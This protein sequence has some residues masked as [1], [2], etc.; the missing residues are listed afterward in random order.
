MKRLFKWKYP[1]LTLLLLM[2]ILAYF[3][4]SNPEVK[5]YLSQN[6]DKPYLFSFIAG[7]M[8]SF[9]FTAP[10]SVGLLITLN[11]SNIY[12]AAALGGLGALIA[13]LFIFNLIKFSFLDEF[14][15][16][17]N[18][19]TI[20]PIKNLIEKE[21]SHKIR[22]YLLYIFAGFVI[23]SPLPDEIGIT[24]LAGLTKIKQ[25]IFSILSFLLNS[26]GILII[27]LLSR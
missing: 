25:S 21:V 26:L 15:K 27:L 6:N 19:K 8:F 17:E 23:A 12:L 1:K 2:I 11:P 20:K 22:N 5:S 16:L 9:G 10:I 24:M 4:F 7:L 18:E 14:K 3:I 13:D